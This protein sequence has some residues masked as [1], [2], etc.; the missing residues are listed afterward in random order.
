MDSS[1]S[2]P[3][4]VSYPLLENHS[5]PFCTRVFQDSF[6]F[7]LIWMFLM[8]PVQNVNSRTL[9]SR[10][11]FF[12]PCSGDG[13]CEHH[14]ESRESTWALQILAGLQKW[15]RVCFPSSHALM[16]V[17]RI[18]LGASWSLWR[19]SVG[20]LIFHE[21]LLGIF[22]LSINVYV[23]WLCKVFIATFYN[24]QELCFKASF[25]T[26]ELGSKLLY[27]CWINGFKTWAK[28]TDSR[29]WTLVWKWF[30]FADLPQWIFFFFAF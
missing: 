29:I 30:P 8:L 1:Y 20:Y 23:I 28:W 24:S 16:Q 14:T 7:H 17:S 2:P 13:G 4:P 6:W 5:I 25:R 3:L 18:K 9:N 26:L 15:R 19:S 21:V 10:E 22:P 12:P 11:P 27:M